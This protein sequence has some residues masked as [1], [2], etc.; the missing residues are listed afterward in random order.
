MTIC[1][2][3]LPILVYWGKRD[4]VGGL[5]LIAIMAVLLGAFLVYRARHGYFLGDEH[6][7]SQSAGERRLDRIKATAFFGVIIPLLVAIGVRQHRE[8][9]AQARAAN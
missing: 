6:L 2:L 5:V 7:A 4:P 1:G 8:A 3:A 9:R